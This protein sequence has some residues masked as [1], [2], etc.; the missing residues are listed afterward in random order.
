MNLLFYI[1]ALGLSKAQ[2]SVRSMSDEQEATLNEI[3]LYSNTR[4]KYQAQAILEVKNDMV[5]YRPIEEW[6]KTGSKVAKNQVNT[7][8]SHSFTVTP[9]PS[10]SFIK[11][12]I[13]DISKEIT[14]VELVDLQGRILA[15]TK[16]FPFDLSA[17]MDVSHC[18]S[19]IYFVKISNATTLELQKVLISR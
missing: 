16:I 4:A 17:E 8:V 13:T 3:A 7:G 11:I 1:Q 6:Q 12:S 18:V 14:N 19:G 9:N 5:F 10:N 2:M 15:Q